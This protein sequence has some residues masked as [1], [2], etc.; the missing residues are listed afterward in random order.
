MEK[1]VETANEMVNSEI[2]GGWHSF[3]GAVYD[4][5]GNF[6][7]WLS[8]HQVFALILILIVL[9]IIV[10]LILRAKKYRIQFKNEAYMKKK[11]IEKKDALIEEQE[12]K[13]SNLQ[14]RLSDQQTVVSEALLRTIRTITGYDADQLPVFFKSLTEISGNPLQM[15]DSQAITTPE[16]QL[17]EREIDES[18]GTNDSKEKLVPDI[19]SLEKSDAKEEVASG[20]DSSE[21]N[22]E[23]KETS[24]SDYSL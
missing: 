15:A 9:G 23:K 4:F 18:S 7:G 17:P 14:K 6:F 21:E 10:W 22:D 2:S 16:S 1:E 5:L 8:T 19:E 24:A 20:D 3:K 13:L 12:N 11:E